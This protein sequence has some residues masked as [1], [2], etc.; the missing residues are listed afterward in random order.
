[1]EPK[2]STASSNSTGAWPAATATATTTAC[3]CSSSPAGYG[4]DPT[5]RCE[6]PDKAYSSGT[7]RRQLRSRGIAAVIPEKSDTI[8]ARERRGSRGG[9]PPKLD[10][11]LYKDR[12]VVERSFALAKQWRALATRYDK[13]TITYRAAVTLCAILTWLR[14][15]GDTP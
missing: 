1:M 2:R 13:L 3:G 10:A 14:R 8:A 7:I 5:L 6:E 15:L 9:R 11:D 12:N 4:P